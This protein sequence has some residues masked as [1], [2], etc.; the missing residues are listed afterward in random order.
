[1]IW[2]NAWYST[3]CIANRST[4]GWKGIWNSLVQ[5]CM[6]LF[7]MEQIH[8]FWNRLNFWF[9]KLGSNFHSMNF[10][11]MEPDHTP[12]FIYSSKS[13]KIVWIG[14]IHSEY[15]NQANCNLLHKN[16]LYLLYVYLYKAHSIPLNNQ[17]LSSLLN[18]SSSSTTWPVLKFIS[19][20]FLYS[21]F[22]L[23]PKVP[24]HESFFETVHSSSFCTF[25]FARGIRTDVSPKPFCRIKWRL[26]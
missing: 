8:T 4:I 13:V 26:S 24:L 9:S 21:L 22:L 6:R 3:Y 19:S 7:Y 2:P 14:G 10:V 20:V 5:Y 11:N 12:Q 17:Y 23:S 25:V 1:M 15:V 16:K 18:K